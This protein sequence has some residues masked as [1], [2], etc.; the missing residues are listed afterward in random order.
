MEGVCEIGP[1]MS[2]ELNT[3]AKIPALGLGTWKSAP[4]DVE[5]TV[6]TAV[7]MGYRHIDCASRYGNEKQI[8]HALQEMFETNIV[9]RGDLWITSKL[10]CTEH[11]P[12]DVPRALESTLQDLQLDYVDLY[13]IH[14]PARLKKGAMGFTPENF[15]PLDIPSTW[16]AMEKLLD[17]GKVHAI[18]VANFSVKKLQDLLTYAKV[19][20]AVNQVECHPVW[21]QHYLHSFCES[22][23][24]HVSAHSP[25]GSPATPGI[26]VK[27]LEH[28]VLKMVA[29]EV[30]KS[31]AQVALRWGIQSGYSVVPKTVIKNEL[32]ENLEVLNWSIPTELF[33][34]FSQIQQMRLV[35]YEYFVHET[36]SPYKTLEELWDGEL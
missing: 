13:L 3:G 8:G 28:P 7:K 5:E 19:V 14:G 21:Q 29:E 34:R 18:G 22:K 33:D 23:G 35:R 1:T 26:K 24:I 27:V 2:F 12:E 4:G 32:Q 17:T 6:K 10:W 36:G 15:A 31:P 11:D 25:L 30:Q 16:K 9:K 20:P